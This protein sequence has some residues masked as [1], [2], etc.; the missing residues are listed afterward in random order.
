MSGATAGALAL[1]SPESVI[2]R[3]LSDETAPEIAKSLGVHRSGLNHFLLTKCP[4]LWRDAQVAR[5]ITAFDNAKA[6]LE[7]ADNAL[8]LARAREQVR[9]AQWEMERLLKRIYGPSQ[10]VTGKD[11]GPVTIEIVQFGS[12]TIEG[13]VVAQ[14][15]E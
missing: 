4:D 10:E 5:A 14:P 11:G 12:R 7:A 6:R 15:K 2:A 13:E 3:Y 9:T 1:V 8:D